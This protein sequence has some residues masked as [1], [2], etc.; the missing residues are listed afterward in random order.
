MI[1]AN[2][3]ASLA[4]SRPH[5]AK[6]PGLIPFRCTTPPV[7]GDDTQTA[8]GGAERQ[9]NQSRGV[10][11]WISYSIWGRLVMKSGA[12]SRSFIMI[13]RRASPAQNQCRN[14]GQYYAHNAPPIPKITANGTL[15]MPSSRNNS[16]FDAQNAP[17]SEITAHMP[18]TKGRF[19][20]RSFRCH[21]DQQLGS[22]PKLSGYL[23]C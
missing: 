17:D 2:H 4:L 3:S 16:E 19:V 23:N 12:T 7:H 18:L 8:K 1:H 9:G 11:P 21:A 6:T 15:K 22:M 5:R 10:P 14:N 13:V 20:S